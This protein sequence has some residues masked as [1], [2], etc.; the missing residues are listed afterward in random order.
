MARGGEAAA[1][2][3]MAPFAAPAA[4]IAE[5]RDDLRIDGSGEDAAIARA[6]EAAALICERFTDRIWFEREGWARLAPSGAWQRI[7]LAPVR[8][9]LSVGRVAGDG[10]VTPIGVGAH[11]I[12]IDAGECAWVRVSDGEAEGRVEVRVTAGA[13]SGWGAVPGPLRQGIVRLA[14]HLYRERGAGGSESESIPPA[15]VAALWRPYR[16]MRVT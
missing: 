2:S 3:G 5:A 8:A 12:D 9:V 6:I 16:R 4:A 14:A 10:S 1:S 11:E 7:G 15:A 13:A